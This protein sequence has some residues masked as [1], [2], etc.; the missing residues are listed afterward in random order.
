ML[1]T[2]RH[3]W[4]RWRRLRRKLRNL[5]PLGLHRD[6]EF[7]EIYA[8]G[9]ALDGAPDGGRGLRFWTMVQFLESTRDL[10]GDTVEAG[11]LFGLAS[12][13]LCRYRKLS[14]PA[15]TGRGHHVIDSF[16][17]FRRLHELDRGSIRNPYLEDLA[18]DRRETGPT[19]TARSRP[20]R[21]FPT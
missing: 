14:D 9:L 5:T 7:A 15:F 16:S 4:R 8:D 21:R 18:K 10:E 6:G 2:Y 1:R 17:G 13:V 3:L 11:C 20:L 12:Y 19:A